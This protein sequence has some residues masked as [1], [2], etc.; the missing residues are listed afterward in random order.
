MVLAGGTLQPIEEMR[1]RLFPGL[2]DDKIHLFSC[3]HIVPPESILPIAIPRGPS[4]KTYDFSYT[5]RSSSEM[6]CTCL[7]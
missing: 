7:Q 6:V 5:S 1:L 3:N 2:S 4:N